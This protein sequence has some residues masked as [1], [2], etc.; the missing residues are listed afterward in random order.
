MIV[1]LHWFW[2]LKYR[3]PTFAKLAVSHSTIYTKEELKG[4]HPELFSAVDM[5]LHI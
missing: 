1:Y 4:S 2:A 3:H 5:W